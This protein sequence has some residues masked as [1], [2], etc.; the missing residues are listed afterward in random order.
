MYSTQKT[1]L[2]TSGIS[3]G[4]SLILT[5]LGVITL[6]VLNIF[7]LLHTWSM[8]VATP[9]FIFATYNIKHSDNMDRYDMAHDGLNSSFSYAISGVLFL[10]FGLMSW[11]LG[12]PT[13]LQNIH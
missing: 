10:V 13:M 5:A 8:I 12:S 4:K 2:A 6:V 3:L 9:A 7:N 11:L 1:G